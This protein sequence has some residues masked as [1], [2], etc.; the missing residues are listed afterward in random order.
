MKRRIVCGLLL[1]VVSAAAVAV[2]NAQAAGAPAA[3]LGLVAKSVKAHIG[4]AAAS[5]GAS[6]YTGDLLSTEQGGSMLVK[7]SGLTLE[8]LDNT[9]VHV[10]A[11]PYGA[12]VEMEHGTVNY[13]TPGNSQNIVIVAS[14]VRV[15]PYLSVADAGRVSMEDP[16]NLTVSTVHGTADVQAGHESRTI[17][18]GKTFRVRSENQVSYRKYLSPDA[19]DYHDYHQHTPC[20]PMQALK[21]HSPVAAGQSRFLYVAGA[22]IGGATWW[23]LSEA[24]ESAKRP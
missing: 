21:G 2:A 20:A 4:N 13:A 15:T 12:V 6:V 3:A 19:S 1:A 7:F 24:T 9:S 8:L 18:Q 11:A 16:C 10:Y 17:E 22:V 23:A 14:D 5:D